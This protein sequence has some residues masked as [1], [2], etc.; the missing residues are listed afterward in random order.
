[1]MNQLY[2]IRFG[3]RGSQLARWQTEYIQLLLQEEWQKKLV[4]TGDFTLETQVISTKGDEVIDKPLPLIGGKGLFT[5]ALEAALYDN[6]IDAAVH[7]LKDLPT[8]SPPGLMLGAIP[9]RANVEDVLVSRHNYTLETLPLGA[10]IGTSSLRRAAQLRHHRPDLR[11]IDIRGNIDTRI[12]KARDVDGPYDA[13]VLA[14]AGLERMGWADAISEILAVDVMVP[15]PGQGALAVQCRVQNRTD[16]TTDALTGT[17]MNDNT[18]THRSNDEFINT[19][20]MAISC[21]ATTATVT[22]ERA[23]LARLEGGCSVP[24]GAYAKIE[25]E[26]LILHGRVTAVDGSQQIDVIETGDVNNA[27]SLGYAVAQKALAQGARKLIK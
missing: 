18:P 24:I 7:S 8:A 15:A 20:L 2:S 26:M 21:P 12:R 9:V 16:H 14:R 1:M 25:N 22:A 4:S 13:I 27:S 5:Q 6:S 11:M 19:M 17:A 23:F 10:Q 3:T